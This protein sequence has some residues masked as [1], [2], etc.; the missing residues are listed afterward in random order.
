MSLAS[1]DEEHLDAF[2]RAMTNLLSTPLAEFTYAQIIDG[3]PTRDTYAREHSHLDGVP[4]MDHHEICP[5]IMEKTRAFRSE[6]DIFSL[7]FEPK[8]VQNYQPSIT[9]EV[10]NEST[11]G[12]TSLSKHIYGLCCLQTATSG[13]SCD[14]LP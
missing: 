3:M 8:V 7:K 1:L 10:A 6:F 9:F 5:G 12:N 4:A 11:A 13:A 14:C 2:K